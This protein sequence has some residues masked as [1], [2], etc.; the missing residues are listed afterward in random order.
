M[1]EQ[2]ENT[3]LS[4]VEKEDFKMYF[5]FATN[6]ILCQIPFGINIDPIAIAQAAKNTALAMLEAQKELNK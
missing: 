6:G 3:G 4:E 2:Q 1:D 5:A